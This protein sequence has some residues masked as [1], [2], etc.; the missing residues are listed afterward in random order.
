MKLF[1]QR[2]NREKTEI[3]HLKYTLITSLLSPN[4]KPIVRF[5][6]ALDTDLHTA[7]PF[8]H[9]SSYSHKLQV[10]QIKS[11]FFLEVKNSNPFKI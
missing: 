6:A 5:D 8:V 9:V 11:Y 10:S 4:I 1:S 7:P 2:F 3:S